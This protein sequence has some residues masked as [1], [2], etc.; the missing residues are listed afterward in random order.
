MKTILESSKFTHFA[1]GSNN[2]RVLQ[3]Y[4]KFSIWDGP[5]FKRGSTFLVNEREKALS[6][7]KL[8]LCF[9]PVTISWR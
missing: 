3:F 2:A 6:C 4:P 9:P 8:A 5:G 1:T 7:R